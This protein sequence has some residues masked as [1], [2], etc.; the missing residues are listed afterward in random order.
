M[1]QQAF[2]TPD[3]RPA[4]RYG[5][6]VPTQ[7]RRLL[8]AVMLGALALVAVGGWVWIAAVRS[9]PPLRYDLLGFQ[10]TTSTSVDI[11]FS[12]E[13]EPGLAV[14]CVLRARGVEGEEVGRRQVIVPAAA[15]EQI[16][17]TSTVRTTGPAVTGEVL[18]CQPYTPASGLRDLG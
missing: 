18:G 12:L 14:A 16:E 17:L 2:R 6:R 13:R 10:P 9:S 5:D 1:T 4:D 11:R 15:T 3:E 7:R 8:V